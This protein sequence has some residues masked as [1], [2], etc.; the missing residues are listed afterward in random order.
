MPCFTTVISK[1]LDTVLNT[2]SVFFAIFIASDRSV[3]FMINGL[4]SFVYL[5]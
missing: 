5:I 4:T 2:V 3:G 1:Y